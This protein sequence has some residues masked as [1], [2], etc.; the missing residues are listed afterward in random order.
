MP[1]NL[2][3]SA[4]ASFLRFDLPLYYCR[5]STSCS[6]SVFY[7]PDKRQDNYEGLRYPVLQKKAETILLMMVPARAVLFEKIALKFDLPLDGGGGKPRSDS[8]DEIFKPDEIKSF[9]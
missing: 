8:A 3:R 1:E 9:Q 7:F 6:R 5:S 2:V 4:R